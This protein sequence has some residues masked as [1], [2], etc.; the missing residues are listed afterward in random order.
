MKTELKSENQE[1]DREKLVGVFQKSKNFGFVVPDDRK[2]KTDIYAVVK[3][4][5]IGKYKNCNPKYAKNGITNNQV[6]LG[7]STTNCSRNLS[8]CIFFIK[9]SANIPNIILIKESVTTPHSDIPVLT[10]KFSNSTKNMNKPCPYNI[11]YRIGHL[12]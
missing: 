11:P 5:A 3:F 2:I 10:R 1:F 7:I 12:S 4:S 6:L 8:W 9:I